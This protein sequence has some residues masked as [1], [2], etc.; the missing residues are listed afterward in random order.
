MLISDCHHSF[1]T[2]DQSVIPQ[3][4]RLNS[5]NVPTSWCQYLVLLASLC[6]VTKGCHNGIEK[7]NS[8][9]EWHRSHP[10]K[11][12]KTKKKEPKV[13]PQFLGGSSLTGWKL[14]PSEYET[15]KRHLKQQVSAITWHINAAQWRFITQIRSC[16]E[17]LKSLLNWLPLMTSRP[18]RT[19]HWEMSSCSR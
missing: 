13:R 8:W 5:I 15:F 3:G 17:R 6:D 14:R 4:G 11:K 19:F 2:P 7:R 9:S 1:Q 10:K 12:T 16:K 18:R